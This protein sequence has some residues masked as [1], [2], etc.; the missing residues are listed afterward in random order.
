MNK[1]LLLICVLMIFGCSYGQEYLDDPK[2]IIRDPHF[3]TYKH[4]RDELES[5]YLN[6]EIT[7]A[8]YL[9]QKNKMDEKYS[10]EVQE[11]TQIISPE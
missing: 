7:Y 1:G 3:N 4:N 5:S 10:Q 8:E 9:E 6:K 11:R 2:S